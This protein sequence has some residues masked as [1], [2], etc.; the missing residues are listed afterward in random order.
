MSAPRTFARRIVLRLDPARPHA[1]ALARAMQL[2]TAFHAELAARM[3]SDTRFAAAAVLAGISGQGDFDRSIETQL[4]R[5]E[6][7]LRR[8]LT[9]LASSEHTAWSFEVVRCA[10]ILAQE[11]TMSSGDLVAIELPGFE[12]SI[13]ELRA[14]VADTLTHARGVILLPSAAQTTQGPVVAIIGDRKAS[15]WLI[16]DSRQIAEALGVPL[17]RLEHDGQIGPA[18]QER[19]EAGDIATAVRRLGATLAVVD[20]ANPI[21]NEL[22]ARPRY[23]RELG[24]PLLLLKSGG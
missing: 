19:R 17:K 8:A 7:S 24:T 20:A 21:V 14:E 10:G 2:A 4:R 1:G 15:N 18:E 13:A 9:A 22:L 16:E 6:T 11:C 12:I 5:A 23:L 3:I